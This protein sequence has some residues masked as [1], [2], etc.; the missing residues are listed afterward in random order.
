M[1]SFWNCHIAWKT[2]KK[3]AWIWKVVNNMLLCVCAYLL[4]YTTYK[5]HATQVPLADILSSC[6]IALTLRLKQK[7][8]VGG[9][10]KK[11]IMITQQNQSKIR[12]QSFLVDAFFFF[13]KMWCLHYPQWSWPLTENHALFAAISCYSKFI[14]SIICET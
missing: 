6:I 11:R 9:L 2:L 4:C 7:W 14:N 8:C 5:Q 12:E 13:V 3:S 1:I 10:S